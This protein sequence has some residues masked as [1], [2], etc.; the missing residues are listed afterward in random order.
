MDKI[1]IR[2]IKENDLVMYW[3]IAY[4]DNLEWM[5]WNGPY[6]NDPIYT[7]E[8]F[9][10]EIGPKYYLNNSRRQV[11][12]YNQEIVGLVSYYFEDEPL[13][14]WPEIGILIFNNTLWGKGIGKQALSIWID[15]IFSEHSKVQRLGFTTWSGNK[16]M[17]A[18]GEKIG[19]KCEAQ[20]RKVRYYDGQ[21]WD[22]VKY[23]ILRSDFSSNK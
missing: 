1:K 12:T 17:M 11:I 8:Q 18:L 20:I 23:G 14:F 7:K 6:F 21:Y 10:N 16:R 3:E 15:S 22:S 5:K 9:I 2:K 19:M 13:N 4:R